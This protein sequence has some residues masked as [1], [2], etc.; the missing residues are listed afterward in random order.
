[1]NYVGHIRKRTV[2][3][4][5]CY[6]L[7]AER[8]SH[9]GKRERQYRT[10][11]NVTKK[12]AQ[13]ALRQWLSELENNGHVSDE[14]I[15]M[16]DL[17]SEYEKL[18]LHE[19]NKMLSP[20]TIVNYKKILE[21][22]LRVTLGH[23]SVQQ[24][25]VRDIQQY[26][27]SFYNGGKHSPKTVYNHL[28]LLKK[29]LDWAVANGIITQNPCES[30]ALQLPKKEKPQTAVLEKAD[31]EQIIQAAEGTNMEFLVKLLF[32][33]GCRRGEIISMTFD[34]WDAAAMTIQIR[35]NR[36]RAE[37]GSVVKKPKMDKVRTI[38]VGPEMNALI[39]RQFVQY[40]ENKLYYGPDFQDSRLMV[41]QPDGAC[42][43]PDSISHKWKRFLKANGL[44]IVGMHTCRHAFAS[45]AL[46]EGCDIA[47]I[48]RYLGHAQTS[49]TLN[50]YV[51]VLNDGLEQVAAD[52][53]TLLFSRQKAQ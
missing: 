17:F 37:K 43:Q 19:G 8:S 47:S 42:Y 22:D 2:K 44:P 4:G 41:C 3:D 14:D 48:S 20:T 46:A 33:T 30:K 16:A 10:L 29:I 49:T 25:S 1:M 21:K 36:V 24:L 31:V 28:L 18:F 9:T 53:D 39:Q 34:D 5:Y 23:L 15:T 26:V 12:Q 38:Y 13:K 51:N 45:L 35:N 27:N 40:K 11:K 6:Q 52:M 7:I 32:A 50:Q